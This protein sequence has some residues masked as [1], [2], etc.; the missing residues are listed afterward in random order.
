MH[1]TLSLL[2]TFRPE[3]GLGLGLDLC[4]LDFIT[5]SQSGRCLK[6]N[7]ALNC[8]LPRVVGNT[9]PGWL[10]GGVGAE[11]EVEVGL[12][13]GWLVLGWFQVVVGSSNWLRVGGLSSSGWLRVCWSIGSS[14][15]GSGWLAGWLIPSSI[16]SGS[17]T[18][19]FI[20]A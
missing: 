10:R 8:S 5:V 20:L 14:G 11:V 16:G 3:L 13:S 12:S 7:I 19:L 1:V 4:F 18:Y 6:L 15:L 9:G 2:S 17:G